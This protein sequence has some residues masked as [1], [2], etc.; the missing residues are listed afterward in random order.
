M[1]HSLFI[2]LVA[3]S[4]TLAACGGGSTS[5]SNPI[6]PPTTAP[7]SYQAQIV[8][9]GTLAG[10][11]SGLSTL[12]GYRSVQSMNQ[13]GILAAPGATPVPIMV[14]SAANVEGGPGYAFGGTVEAVVSPMPSALPQ[15]A[16]SQTNPNAVIQATPSPAP[17]A[18]PFPLSPGVVGVA[19]INGTSAANPQAAGAASAS[20]ANPVNATVSVPVYSYGVIEVNCALQYPGDAAGFAW[21]GSSWTPETTVA[22]SDIYS[23]EPLSGAPQAACAA[24]FT[25]PLGTTA[26][27]HFPYGAVAFSDDTP[28][29]SLTA[30]QW[31]NAFTSIS[32][33]T[34]MAPNPD[35]SINAEILFKTANGSI[36]KIFPNVVGGNSDQ[37][38]L[39][40]AV[41]VSGDSIDGF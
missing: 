25:T 20:L 5:G 1:R 12:S 29:S 36:A 15:V 30:S 35:G 31:S 2:F 3:T 11:Q 27:I 33:T 24:P 21:N 40:G 38:D 7:V 19:D 37:C 4:L 17:G 41:E 39:A 16:F 18:T 6:A 26:M 28:F 10:S 13:R 8:F 22:A 34:L 32:C 9:K 23:T 14:I